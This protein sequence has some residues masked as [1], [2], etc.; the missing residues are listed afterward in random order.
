MA[1][2]LKKHILKEH[3]V[4]LTCVSFPEPPLSRYDL[5][6]IELRTQLTWN[7]IR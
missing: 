4:V 5:M 1:V 6:F 2:N 3:F 7:E